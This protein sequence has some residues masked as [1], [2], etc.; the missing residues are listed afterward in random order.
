MRPAELAT[1]AA[2]DLP[3]FQHALAWLWENERYRPEVVVQLRPTSPLRPPGLI[4]D[5]VRRLA[6]CPEADCVRSV[7]APTQNP[8]KMWRMGDG[9][10]LQPLLSSEFPEPYNMPRQHLPPTYWQTGHL[11]VIRSSTIAKKHT[12]TGDRVLPLMMDEVFCVD[13]DSE[14]DWANAEDVIRS[15][16]ASLV[17]PGRRGAEIG[18]TSML[19]STALVVCDFDGVFTDNRV[20]VSETGHE[21]V[22]CNRADGLGIAALR[23]EGIEVV[24]LSSETNPVVTAR[25]RKLGIACRQAIQDKRAALEAMAAEKGIPL[26]QVIYLGNDANDLNCLRLAGLGV[27]VADAHASV[28]ADAGLV[29]HSAGGAGAVREL[30][31]RILESRR[32]YA[33]AR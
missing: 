8:Y 33:Q 28:V 10:Y 30:C 4:D 6:A 25:C 27:I 31:D 7:A 23:G 2:P 9:G 14:P 16:P 19:A 11:D 12:L 24:V 29:L 3:L 21:S 1:D 26:G 18:V 32:R 5:G 13:I 20:W 17:L 15:R 22:V